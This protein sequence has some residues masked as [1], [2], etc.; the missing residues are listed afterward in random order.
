MTLKFWSGSS[1]SI[2]TTPFPTMYQCKFG[3]S[4]STG[5]EDNARKR[6]YAGPQCRQDLH[7]KQYVPP[8]LGCG[9]K[10]INARIAGG[11]RIVMSGPYANIKTP[12]KCKIGDVSILHVHF[13]QKIWCKQSSSR[14]RCACSMSCW[15]NFMKL[16]GWGTYAAI[17][18]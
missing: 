5:L 10:I 14:L 15:I 4:P 17:F 12:L 13:F 6:S 16:V 7:Q 8:P 3:Q 18:F 2:N 1:K 11:K 9:N